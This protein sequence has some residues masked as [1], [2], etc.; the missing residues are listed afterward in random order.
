MIKRVYE[1]DPLVCKRCGGEMCIIAFI[2][3]PKVV[4]KIIRHLTADEGHRER[5]PPRWAG[6]E[7][8][9]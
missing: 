6:L 4:D 7:A 3:D 5:A 8:A 1:V 9:S 2:V